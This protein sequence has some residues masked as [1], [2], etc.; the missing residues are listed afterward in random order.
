MEKERP[1]PIPTAAVVRVR[2]R[3][4]I[5]VVDGTNWCNNVNRL[6]NMMLI[7]KGIDCL[8]EDA[9]MPSSTYFRGV[10]SEGGQLSR[11]LSQNKLPNC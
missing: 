10:T 6:D 4:A 7:A 1:R 8:C 3:D 11:L 2:R 9:C 5:V